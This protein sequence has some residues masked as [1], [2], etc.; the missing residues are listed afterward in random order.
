MD[1]TK[2]Y[3]LE[4]TTPHLHIG[5]AIHKILIDK[6]I[7]YA[8]AARRTGVNQSAFKPYLSKKS[9]QMGVLWNVSLALEHNFLADVMN[10][11]PA[12]VLHNTT[13]QFVTTIAEQAETIKDLQKEIE[14]YKKTLKIIP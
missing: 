12:N 13:A 1:R 9:L 7:S 11:L 2:K 14:I 3:K 5:K 6:R 10:D 8:E 4:S